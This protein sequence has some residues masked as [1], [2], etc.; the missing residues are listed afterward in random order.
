MYRLTDQQKSLLDE[1]SLLADQ[2]IAPHASEVDAQE[3]FPRLSLEALAHSGWLGLAVG[4]EYGGNGQGLRVACAALDEIAQRCASS[5]MVYL[6]HLCGSACFTAHATGHEKTLRQISSGTCLATLAWSERGSRSH[7]WAPVSQAS[8]KDGDVILNAEKSFVTSAGEADVYVVSTRLPSDGGEPGVMLY[9]VDKNDSGFRVSGGWS[10]LGMRGNSSAPM[11]LEDCR[12]PRES[13][14]CEEGQ[15]FPRMLEILPWFSLGSAAISVGIAEA[16]TRA[17]VAHLTTARLEHLDSR[18]ADLPTL[19]ARAAAMRIETDRARAH[20]VSALDAV[21][22][23]AANAMLLVLESKAAAAESAARVTD[24]GMQACG[25]A[26]FT[27]NLPLERYF[28]DARAAGVMA[29]TTDVLHDFIGRA[30]CGM[31]LF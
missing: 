19:R 30:I 7:F 13:A 28:R 4:P 16:A 22:S 17:T 15:G 20:V 29:P 1:L 12:I 26:A 31:E 24:L 2:H 18:L 10:A 11:A 14:L 9:A 27:H 23:N 5:A 3:R 8:L 25:G 21:E 6:M